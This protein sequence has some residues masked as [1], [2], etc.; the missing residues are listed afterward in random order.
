MLKLYSVPSF[1]LDNSHLN[2]LV[3]QSKN[4]ND[5]PRSPPP[6]SQAHVAPQRQP[7][8][9]HYRPIHVCNVRLRLLLIVLLAQRAGVLQRGRTSRL[10]LADETSRRERQNFVLNHSEP[11]GSTE[12]RAR[13]KDGG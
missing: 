13:T 11:E 5:E 9:V 6:I 1:L 3:T 8:P 10:D 7:N 12:A 4:P 2:D